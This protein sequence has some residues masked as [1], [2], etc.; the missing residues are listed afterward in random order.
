V[1]G[2]DV[3]WTCIPH[4]WHFRDADGDGVP[5]VK[6]RLLSGFGV[7]YAFRGHDMHGLRFG[8]DGKLYFS[9]GDRGVN[10]QSKEGRQFVEPDTGSVM[11]CNPDG[12]GFEIFATGLATRARR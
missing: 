2:A 4:L 3:W 8:P 10:V 12:T 1:R 9:I 5:E 11:R 7:K 6:E